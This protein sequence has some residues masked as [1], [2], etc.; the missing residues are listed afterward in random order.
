MSRC[1]VEV[2]VVMEM[3]DGGGVTPI[4]AMASLAQSLVSVTGNAMLVNSTVDK[5]YVRS[6]DIPSGVS[7][8]VAP[9]EG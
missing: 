3:S 6:G 7:G 4:D 9:S 2:T 5:A 1:I 8:G